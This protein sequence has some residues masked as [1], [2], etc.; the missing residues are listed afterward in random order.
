M[1]ETLNNTSCDR[2]DDLISFLYGESDE[3]ETNDFK[4]HLKACANCQNEFVSLGGVRDSIA[5]WKAE[6]FS[7]PR[8]AIAA[9]TI[10][11]RSAAA[12]LREFFTLSPLWLKGAVSFA[13]ILFCVMAIL[14]VNRTTTT[15]PV[16]ESAKGVKQYS[17]QEMKEAVAKALRDQARN[18]AATTATNNQTEVKPLPVTKETHQVFGANRT[19]Q[20]ASHK[21]LSRAERQQLAS[22]LRLLGTRDEDT[23]N[24]I[25]DRIN[26]EFQR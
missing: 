16:V 7:A 21:P 5:L 12:A 26:D 11:R 19:A 6:A 2:A 4:L 10:Q 23:L 24:L 20:W 15:P 9:A 17:E 1:N 18:L 13:A 25:G 14:L 3:R 8:V 22:D